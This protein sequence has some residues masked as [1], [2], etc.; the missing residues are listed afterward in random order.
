VSADFPQSAQTAVETWEALEGTEPVEGVIAIDVDGIRSLLRAVGPVEAEGV[1][2]TADSVRGQLLRKQYEDFADRDDRRDQIG[3]VAKVIFGRIESG[4]WELSK[5]VTELQAAV[6][7]RHLMI[8]S[9]DDPLRSV[10]D[11]TSAD[12]HLEPDSLAISLLNRSGN[13]LDSWVDTT[14]DV[15]TVPRADGSTAITITYQV[16]NRS[17]GEG[18]QYIVGPGADGLAAGD[19]RGL[20]V[21]NLPA[22][23]SDVTIDGA[24]VFLEG[25]DGPTVVIGGE[26]TVP[27][28]TKSTVTVRATLPEGLDELTLEPAARIPRTVWRVN[29]TTYERDRRQ[30][31]PIA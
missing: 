27:A 14:A 15:E 10:W 29:T 24:R 25:G 12:G 5:M 8:W 28:S 4:D 30:R 18:P 20:V 2:Y 6:A 23:S 3:E 26:I 9:A 13:K 31:V 17:T 11:E 7:G 1:L 19:Y 22:G 16:D 21:A